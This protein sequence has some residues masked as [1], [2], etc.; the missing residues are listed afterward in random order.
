M[1]T[2]QQLKPVE[3]ALVP[4][5]HVMLRKIIVNWEHKLSVVDL[6]SQC[7]SGYASFY[8]QSRVYKVM[9]VDSIAVVP[10]CTY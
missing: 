2:Y 7:M 10:T 8:D 5:W 6:S 9:Y 4:I 1:N 3:R